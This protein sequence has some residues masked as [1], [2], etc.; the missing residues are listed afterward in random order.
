MQYAN[1]RNNFGTE[2]RCESGD[3]LSDLDLQDL[4]EKFKT[5]GVLLFRDFQPDLDQ[6]NRFAEQFGTDYMTYKGGGYIRRKV[7]EGI[8]DTL[9]SV[10]YD[11]GREQDTFG[12]PLH[13]EMYY[14]DHRP[15]SL[16]FYCLVPASSE[17]ETTICDG[18]ELYNAL[19]DESK[20]LLNSKPLKYIRTYHDGEWQKIY[21]TEDIDEA[22]SF[23]E[24]NGLSVKVDTD[25]NSLNT[26]YIQP[27]V[28]T[29]RWGDHKIYI[30]NILTVQWQED[31]GRETSIVRFED[32]EP[33]P[34]SMIDE[35]VAIQQR[36]MVPIA[37]NK[38]D[39]AYIDNTRTLHGRRAFTDT[40][41]DVYLRMVKTVNY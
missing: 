5:S 40:N 30:N 13:G 18:N 2:I 16:W 31:M 27:G 35:V 21:E 29:S 11:H 39:F 37:W 12:L 4:I 38:G 9:L 7:N 3:S 32:G 34:R 19:S 33:I 1:I 22:V 6:F 15:V 23:A 28:I 14:I 20:Q 36:I 17:G 41:R 10:N 8:D 25:T 24:Y 26:E